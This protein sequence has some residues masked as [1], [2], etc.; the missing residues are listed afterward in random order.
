MTSASTS[1]NVTARKLTI[2]YKCSRSTKVSI[3][4][5][6]QIGV[7]SATRVKGK[8]DVSPH[9]RTKTSSKE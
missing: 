7:D 8:M 6:S 4:E 5:V 2:Q 1:V 9:G 3:T